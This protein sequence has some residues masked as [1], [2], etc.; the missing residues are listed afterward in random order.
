MGLLNVYSYG[1]TINPHISY[2]FK[3]TFFYNKGA[4]EITSLTYYVKS[5][6]LPVW[7]MN[8]ETR[9]RFGNTQYV[10][11]TFDFGQSTLKIVFLENDGM[12]VSYFLNGFL[13]NY[14]E[15]LDGDMNLWNNCASEILKIKIDELDPSMRGTIVSNI[16]ACHLKRLSTPHF[17]SLSYGTPVEVEA[18]FVV[19]YKINSIE[20]EIGALPREIKEPETLQDDILAG[21]V[22]EEENRSLIDAKSK[23]AALAVR[24]RMLTEAELEK[25]KKKRLAQMDKAE[26]I[27]AA[28]R[29]TKLENA[30]KDADKDGRIVDKATGNVYFVTA[31]E[32]T[33]Y[34]KKKQA[35]AALQEQNIKEE[36][37][38]I[39]DTYG[40]DVT[41]IKNVD[42]LGIQLKGKLSDDDAADLTEAIRSINEAS[43]E[44]T[45]IKQELWKSEQS[46]I[47]EL[48]SDAAHKNYMGNL[49]AN[50]MK[51]IDE[52]NEA[53]AEVEAIEQRKALLQKANDIRQSN[54]SNEEK[55]AYIEEL[56]KQISEIDTKLAKNNGINLGGKTGS[57][58]SNGASSNGDTSLLISKIEEMKSISKSES[59]IYGHQ[60]YVDTTSMEFK[61]RSWSGDKTKGIDCSGFATPILAAVDQSIMNYAQS[62]KKRLNTREIQKYMID[63]PELYEEVEVEEGMELKRGDIALRATTTGGSGK[64]IYR[65]HIMFIDQDVSSLSTKTA[66]KTAESTGDAKNQVQGEYMRSGSYIINGSSKGGKYKI[67]RLRKQ[68]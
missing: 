19:R 7:N 63:H 48:N 61:D 27:A 41:K 9:Q 50:N 28:R 37:A 46:T 25:I 33:K 66:V 54:M 18:E 17:T 6:E 45:K 42:E 5:V 68:V 11:P 24:Q 23:V 30:R 59:L 22:Q 34:I 2:R 47:V 62:D 65:D 64:D 16:Y 58:S 4:E 26:G 31:E 35:E 67:Y 53:K 29:Y 13:F 55:I 36:L 20:T 14:R 8:T 43:D 51:F 52:Y 21:R 57:A 60:D 44:L 49:D 39:Y 3:V 10:I 38:Y 56:H 32:K 1:K 12:N 40:V 15:N